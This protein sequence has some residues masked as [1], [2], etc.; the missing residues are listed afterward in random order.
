MRKEAIN[1]FGEGM[2]MD[3]NPL[4][5]PNNVLTSALNATIITYNGNEFVLQ[6]DMGN[7]RVET[8]YLPAGY[9]PVGVKE[10]GGIIYVASYNP[11]TNKGQVGSFPSPERNISSN[12]IQGAQTNL[13]PASFGSITNGVL[14]TFVTKINVFPEGT[15]IRSGDKFTIMFDGAKG[16]QINT[17]ILRT[18][19]SGCFDTANG[20]P[21]SPKNKLMTLTLT[22]SDSNGYLRDITD[23]LKRFDQNN[24]TITFS[25]SDAP[26]YKTNV[27]YYIQTA[28]RDYSSNIDEYRKTYPANVYNNKLSGEL[29]L[30]ASLNIV[31]SIDVAVTGYVKPDDVGDGAYLVPNNS[32]ITIPAGSKYALMYDVKYKYN[33]PDGYFGPATPENSSE[34]LKLYNSYYGSASDFGAFSNVIQG[35]EFVLTDFAKSTLQ[36]HVNFTDNTN[37]PVFDLTNKQYTR[38]QEVQVNLPATNGNLINYSVTPCMTY[39]RLQGLTASST[40]DL[41]KIGSGL[42]ELN[43]WKYYCN[44]TS[45]ILAWGMEAYLVEG[46]SISKVTFRFYRF[47]DGVK[48]SPTSE[49]TVSAKRNY[50]G[51]FTDVLRFGEVIEPNNIYLVEVQKT[52]KRNG[53]EEVDEKSEYRWLVSSPLYNEAYVSTER[54]YNNFD[55]STVKKYNSLSILPSTTNTFTRRVNPLVIDP[56]VTL[57]PS[58]EED[59]NFKGFNVKG[60]TMYTYEYDLVTDYA[61]SLDTKYPFQLNGDAATTTYETTEE[62]KTIHKDFISIGPRAMP[63]D[64]IVNTDFEK[65]ATVEPSKMYDTHKYTIEFKGT[66]LSISGVAMSQFLAGKGD[67]PKTMVYANLYR[68]F[69]YDMAKVFG[70]TVPKSGS[71]YFSGTEVGVSVY[72][73]GK[74]RRA[75]LNVMVRTSKNQE[76]QRSEREFYY[77]SNKGTRQDFNNYWDQ[78]MNTIN[79]TFSTYPTC[80]VFGCP[81]EWNN[82]GYKWPSKHYATH[83]GGLASNAIASYQ[84]LL[85][86]NGS[87]YVFVKDFVYNSSSGEGSNMFVSTE[88]AQCVYNVYKDVYIQSEEATSRKFWTYDSAD[89]VYNPDAGL[90][91]QN[92]IKCN[93]SVKS[94]E[95]L[96]LNDEYLNT[97][98]IKTFVDGFGLEDST[99]YVNLMKFYIKTPDEQLLEIQGSTYKL[100]NE[101]NLSTDMTALSMESVYS[102]LNSYATGSAGSSVGAMDFNDKLYEID[103][104]GNEFVAN[105]I[106]YKEKTGEMLPIELS[107]GAA[108][109]K[110]LK[111]KDGTLLVNSVDGV[112]KDFYV[113]RDSSGK[114]DISMHFADFPVVDLPIRSGSTTDT[115]GYT[116]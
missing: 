75:Y 85:W 5:T 35:C 109:T 90:T 100:D 65:V 36:G 86:F 83:T 47:P 12:E 51:V 42:V 23:Q 53:V 72:S 74:T 3:L 68:P 71:N 110:K 19:L 22:V 60:A 112:T 69:V 37:H 2:L 93:S 18:Y 106:Y 39:S 25:E 88:M 13:T 64:F 82:K 1:T 57:Q 43:V 98:T 116:N 17:D 29:I 15:I 63:D 94:G 77:D 79:S 26:L 107:T 108:L 24:K 91:L 38:D 70:T 105:R 30:V 76:P 95:L 7:G 20:K 111:L 81:S 59:P 28:S 50:N 61:M 49:F 52:M 80:V 40:I 56:D 96:K 21:K 102:R 27:G 16:S 6:N 4:T 84:M 33:C 67:T 46:T 9:V 114:G 87:T 66:K 78:L 89:Y 34:V 45:V 58:V 62:A 44:D 10:Y 32:G 14:D 31:D 99:P 48:D 97:N 103:G 113:Y 41:S 11:I 104:N 73:S 55:E 54:D 115:W 8:A 101:Y 92:V